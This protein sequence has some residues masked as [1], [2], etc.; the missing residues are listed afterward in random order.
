LGREKTP[1][2]GER[3]P[4]PKPQPPEISEKPMT[5]VLRSHP[6]WLTAGYVASLLLIARGYA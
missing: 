4:S 1:S 3:D 6:F 5:R 2:P